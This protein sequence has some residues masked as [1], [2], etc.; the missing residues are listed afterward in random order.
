MPVC[1]WEDNFR[2][3]ILNTFLCARAYMTVTH[4]HTHTHTRA[5][6]NTPSRTHTHQ[7]LMHAHTRPGVHTHSIVFSFS[8]PLFSLTHTC[9]RARKHTQTQTHTP[10]TNNSAHI[11][12]ALLFSFA[13]KHDAQNSITKD[14]ARDKHPDPQSSY[15]ACTCPPHSHAIAGVVF[16][17]PPQGRRV[18]LKQLAL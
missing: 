1:S 13:R 12:K 17:P 15:P 16:S 8:L 7:T 9:A 4:T 10:D 14:D 3:K 11:K 5:H 18:A 6:A 2:K